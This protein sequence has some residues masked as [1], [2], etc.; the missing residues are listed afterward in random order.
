MIDLILLTMVFL[1]V[2]IASAAIAI[3][4]TAA[5]VLVVTA[6][7]LAARRRDGEVQ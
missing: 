7:L 5:A 1:A 6:E 4:F 2:L 3:P